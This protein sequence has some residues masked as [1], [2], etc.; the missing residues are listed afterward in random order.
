[1]QTKIICIFTVYMQAARPSLTLKN[2]PVLQRK[3]KFHL[4]TFVF[5]MIIWYQKVSAHT[6]HRDH[7]YQSMLWGVLLTPHMNPTSLSLRLLWWCHEYGN[8]CYPYLTDAFQISA[9]NIYH[10]SLLKIVYTTYT[11][12]ILTLS[13]ISPIPPS[14]FWS[15]LAF[16]E[17]ERRNYLCI[18]CTLFQTDCR[19]HFYGRFWRY[20]LKVFSFKII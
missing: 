2:V 17:A 6:L 19:R 14:F 15:R 4:S 10:K 8:L 1:L 7:S 13:N 5:F 9:R 12:M 20:L 18:S 11:P 3:K 16:S